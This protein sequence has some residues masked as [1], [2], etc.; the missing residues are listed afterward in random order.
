MAGGGGVLAAA[1]TAV[2]MIGPGLNA[3][4]PTPAE[5][6]AYA[7]ATQHALPAAWQPTDVVR[8]E[9]WQTRDVGQLFLNGRN[10]RAVERERQQLTTFTEP[11]GLEVTITIPQRDWV[12]V[13]L[14]AD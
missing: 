12:L 6:P 14:D 10:V 13:D 5:N 3:P 11:D 7:G 4:Q 9:H 8:A 2:L 1:A